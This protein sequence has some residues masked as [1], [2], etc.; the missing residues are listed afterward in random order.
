MSVNV[1]FPGHRTVLGLFWK[2]RW[3]MVL[4]VGEVEP[5]PV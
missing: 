2:W 4:V 1:P 3:R 5:E